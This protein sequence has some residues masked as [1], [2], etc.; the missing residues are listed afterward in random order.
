MVRHLPGVLGAAQ[1]GCPRHTRCSR[2]AAMHGQPHARSRAHL[3]G[4]AIAIVGEQR[5]ACKS[6]G[7]RKAGREANWEALPGGP[8]GRAVGCGIQRC[9]LTGCSSLHSCCRLLAPPAGPDRHVSQ[10]PT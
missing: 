5:Q 7:C 4:P 2:T 10:C 9:F 6:I 1:P 3:H 8:I